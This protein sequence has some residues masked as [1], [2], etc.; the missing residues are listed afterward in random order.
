MFVQQ[1]LSKYTA[2]D[3]VDQLVLNCDVLGQQLVAVFCK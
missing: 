2:Q 3:T 1:N